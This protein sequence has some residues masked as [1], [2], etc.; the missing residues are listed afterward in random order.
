MHLHAQ[1][2]ALITFLATVIDRVSALI[3]TSISCFEGL[4]EYHR[5]TGNERWKRAALNV[6]A[7]AM[8]KETAIIGAQS[9]YG[10]NEGLAPAEQFSH[11]AFYQ[12]CPA[13]DGLG[14]R[15]CTHAGWSF[16]AI[17]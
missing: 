14:L 9:G 6:F 2:A 13:R 3:P 7:N 16:A 4:L 12:T 5:D 8:A 1:A 10:P 17:S 11:T 15:G